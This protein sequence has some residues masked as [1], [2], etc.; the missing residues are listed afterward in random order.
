MNRRLTPGPAVWPVPL[1]VRQAHIEWVAERMTER[2]WRIVET[3]NRLRIV[4]GAQ[5]ERL[6]FSALPSPR[7]R[8]VSRSRVLHRLV[9]WR[10][11]MPLG[12][13][14]GGVGR[15]S[16]VMA[17]ALDSAGQRLLRERVQRRESRPDEHARVRRSVAPGSRTLAHTLAVTEL[18]VRLVEL[19]RVHGFTVAAFD[20]EP[21]AWWPN[22]LRGYLKPDAYVRLAR[23]DVIDH[24]WVEQDMATEALPTIRAKLT[25]YLDFVAR[26]QL[27]PQGLLPRVLVSTAT[28]ARREAVAVVVTRLPAPAA[29]LFAVVQDEQA[30]RLLYE[31]LRE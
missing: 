20:A 13:R 6:S 18:Y 9:S 10:V 26:G 4:T 8:T 23:G 22:G 31:V 27:G 17:F 12:R 2:D 1:R 28:A 15:G 29:E 21:G 7:S 24:W 3:V 11:L 16:S 14:I 5:V 19:S 30:A 25:A